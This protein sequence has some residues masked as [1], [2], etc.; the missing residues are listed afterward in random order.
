MSTMSWLANGGAG[1]AAW[2][3]RREWRVRVACGLGGGVVAV[4][5]VGDGED[6][7]DGGQGG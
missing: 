7:A 3:G 4:G 5:E 2:A 6:D 1:G